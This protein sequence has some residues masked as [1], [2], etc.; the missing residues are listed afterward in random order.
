MQRRAKAWCTRDLTLF[1]PVSTPASLK[2]ERTPTRVIALVMEADTGPWLM[3]VQYERTARPA[4]IGGKR[5]DITPYISSRKIRNF[6]TINSFKTVNENTGLF[7]SLHGG[8][9]M[10]VRQKPFAGTGQQYFGH[11]QRRARE[12]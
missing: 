9:V 12:I 2:N 8:I 6:N 3:P 11:H 7:S 4:S 1:H 10:L 5:P